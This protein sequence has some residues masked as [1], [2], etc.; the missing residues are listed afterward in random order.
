MT[1]TI[2]TPARTS[3]DHLSL[4]RFRR[5]VVVLAVIIVGLFVISLPAHYAYLQTMC[6]EGVCDDQRLSPEGMAEFQKIGLPI[7]F[8]AGYM[9]VLAAIFGGVCFAIAGLIVRRGPREPMALLAV[10]M[11]LLF[12]IVFPATP[13]ALAAEYSFPLWAIQGI[14]VLGFASII[15]FVNLFPIG[16]FVPRWTLWTSIGWIAAAM[17]GILLPDTFASPWLTMLNTLG[18]VGCAGASLGA[19]VYRYRR[20]TNIIQ[21]QQVKWVILGVTAGIGAVLGVTLLGIIIPSL[22]EPGLYSILVVPSMFTLSVLLIPLSLAMAVLRSRLW[23]VDPVINRA[24]V[25]TSLT[26]SVVGI[27][28]L[29]VGYLGTLLQTSNDLVISLVTTGIVA[30]LFQPLRERFQYAVNHLM[31]GERDEPYVVLSRLGQRL[32]DSLSPN[33]VLPT[34]VQTVREAL[35]LPYAAISLHQDGEFNIVAESGALAQRSQHLPLVYQG[36]TVGELL[37]GLRPGEDA[38][39]D[40]DLRLLND[41]ARQAGIAAHGVQ[42][43][44]DLQRSRER[45]VTAREEERRRLRR[46]LHDGLGPQLAS[47][48][49]TIDAAVKLL[50][51][52]PQA[53]TELLQD[54]KSQSQ[55]AVSDIRRLVYELRPP[56]LDDLGLLGALQSQ[57][58]RYRHT[59]LDITITTSESMPALPAAVEVACYRIVLEALTNT[60]R[61]AQARAC[62]VSLTMT[63]SMLRVQIDDDGHGLP[64]NDH[65]GIG[66]H[67]MRERAEELGGSLEIEST[68]GRGT[69]I[70]AWL[71]VQGSGD[72]A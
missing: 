26:A 66:R 49:L 67:S 71:P 21:R 3:H 25:Y 47:Q 8:Y 65:A 6:V 33:T 19:L 70:T 53:A 28:V 57:A 30:I 72:D 55:A 42:L 69:I 44:A 64:E 23:D 10:A 59:G 35:K 24:L 48:T 60:I 1:S 39:S 18:F 11:L 56:A 68:R 34:V 12:G 41:L 61:H 14:G 63:A 16:R 54:L 27:Y 50:H 51:E 36:E 32:R 4:A 17:Q 31:Y 7:R 43:T 45:L 58:D 20:R 52:N 2:Y 15:L 46:D 38:F 13:R 62:T 9:T 5:A 29:I 40:A 37:L 22:E